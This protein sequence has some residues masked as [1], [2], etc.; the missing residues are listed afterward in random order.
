MQGSAFLS[1]L[2]APRLFREHGGIAVLV[3][4]SWGRTCPLGNGDPKLGRP[5]SGGLRQQSSRRWSLTSLAQ[6][7]C[8]GK[9]SRKCDSPTTWISTA[10]ASVPVEVPWRTGSAECHR[11]ATKIIRVAVEPHG[12]H[13]RDSAIKSSF[14]SEGGSAGARDR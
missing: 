6:P 11:E 10:S 8:G 7:D 3:Y 14:N 2:S 5:R 12:H 4:A 9:K 1:H 13:R